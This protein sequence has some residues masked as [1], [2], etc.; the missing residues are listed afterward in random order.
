MK[1]EIYS[2]FELYDKLIVE[3]EGNTAGYADACAAALAVLTEG[4]EN[5]KAEVTEHITEKIRFC[6][7][8][9]D[10]IYKKAEVNFLKELRTLFTQNT[11]RSGGARG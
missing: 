7:R 1:D 5:M 8:N 2:L 4:D 11:A 6:N 10:W 9:K 3:S